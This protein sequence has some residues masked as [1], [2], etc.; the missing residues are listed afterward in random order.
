ML[1]ADGGGGTGHEIIWQ[2]PSAITLPGNARVTYNDLVWT[3]LAVKDCFTIALSFAY[4]NSGTYA[5]G[6]LLSWNG[7]S[8]VNGSV[9]VVGYGSE[10]WRIR[11]YTRLSNFNMSLDVDFYKLVIVSELSGS[12]RVNTGYLQGENSGLGIAAL[13]SVNNTTNAQPLTFGD[14]WNRVIG[15]IHDC[16]FYDGKFSTAEIENYLGVSIS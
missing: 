7:S 13:Q 11:D 2:L 4:T 8:T 10:G 6:E 9:N 16:T 14:P 12:N 3:D 5:I 15:T 1:A